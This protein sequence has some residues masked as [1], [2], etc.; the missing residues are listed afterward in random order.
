MSVMDEGEAGIA[1]G[2][3]AV[4]RRRFG[5]AARL[6]NLQRLSG[7]ASQELWSFDAETDAGRQPLILRRNPG[8]AVKRETA[9]GMETEA[10]LIGL[11]IAAGA[12]A[13]PVAHVLAPE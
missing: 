3:A 7:G 2:L 8:G 1:A 13:P 10:R 6:A 4:V 9:A 11:A 12:P 5:A